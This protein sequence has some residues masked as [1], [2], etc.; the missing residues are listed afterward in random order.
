M[1]CLFTLVGE[2]KDGY[3]HGHGKMIFPDGHIHE[4][5]WDA[6]VFQGD[7]SSCDRD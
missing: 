2:F 5:V 1:L 7:H 6:D 3:M 4:G